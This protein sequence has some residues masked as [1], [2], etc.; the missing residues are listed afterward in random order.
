MI[1]ETA[2]VAEARR[3]L[4]TPFHHQ[5]R[6][7]GVGV[8]CAGV[9]VEVAKACG[10]YW[11]DRAGYGRIPSRGLFRA[12]VEAATDPVEFAALRPGDLMLFAWREETQHIAIVSCL[13]PLRLIHAW[14]EAGRCVENDCDA[15]WLARLVACRRYRRTA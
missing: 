13:T 12:T 3:W 6:V 1:T 5:G 8:D 10:L 14:Q 4:G 9:A 11:V 15:T 2:I 7:L